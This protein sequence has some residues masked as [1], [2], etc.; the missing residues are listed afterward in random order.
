[1]KKLPWARQA[2]RGLLGLFIVALTWL[3]LPLGSN[4]QWAISLFAAVV[5][6]LLATCGLLRLRAPAHAPADPFSRTSWGG[7]AVLALLV[8]FTAW[9]SVQ[10]TPFGYTDDPHETR[11]Y[12]LR[13]IG[14]VGAFWLVQLLVTS[15][16]RRM[17]LLVGLL[18]AGVI[19]ALIAMVLF[20]S[21][22][23]YEYLGFD[24]AQGMRATGTF[25]QAD[26]L[27]NYMLLTFSA[28]LAVMLTQMGHPGAPVKAAQRHRRIQAALEF[29]MS[30]KMV[31]RLML[32]TLVIALV[33]TRSRMGNGAFFLGLFIVAVWV[34]A[35]ST[36]LRK[37]AG[38]LVVSLL[39]VDLIVIG[40]WVGLSKVLSRME[41]TEIAADAA[42]AS[43]TPVTGQPSAPPPRREETLEERTRP[44]RDA[45]AMLQE[46]P[47]TGFGGGAF[48]NAFTRYKVESLTLP[49]NHAHNDYV[50]IAA[51]VG[52]SGLLLLAGVA[53]LTAV[54]AYRLMQDGH[55]PHARGVAAGVG[56]ALLCALLHALVDLNLQINANAMTLTVLLAVVWSVPTKRTTTSLRSR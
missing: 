6:L 33:L 20:S 30:G 24:F 49:Y 8:L 41:A 54:R 23:R 1:M 27:A 45:M 18:G 50:E 2:E 19:Q 25:P 52:L 32:V 43:Q 21:A 13:C 40:Q 17:A 14:Y 15:D 34:M 11:I 35:R 39:V 31:V 28:G 51:D 37:S 38:I 42:S 36:N 46:R 48:Y 44:V 10:L 26:A 4:R 47:W 22:G 9:T 29:M 3:P 53:L 16:R 12:V 55:S 5:W 56:M 7:H